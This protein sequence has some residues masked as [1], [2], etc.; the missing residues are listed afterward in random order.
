M[1]TTIDTLRNLGP[2]FAKPYDW[3]VSFPSFSSEFFPAHVLQ[4]TLLSFQSGHMEY[5]VWP[6]NFPELSIRGKSL[7]LEIYDLGD[8][9]VGFFLKKWQKAIQGDDFTIR[10]LM[11]PGVTKELILNR[12]NAQRE[13]VTTE[14]Y[15]VIPEGDITYNHT[16]DKG[17][18]PISVTVNLSIV[19]AH[20]GGNN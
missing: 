3:E 15:D 16:S 18:T 5:G 12:L 6:F 8:Y 4:D 9:R 2:D 10:L 13:P 1:A 17:G 14:S 7:S 11:Q 19:G 20:N